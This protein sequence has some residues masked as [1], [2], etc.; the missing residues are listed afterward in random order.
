ME[1]ASLLHKH[2][3]QP[4]SMHRE[5]ARIAARFRGGVESAAL[6]CGLWPILDA[7]ALVSPFIPSHLTLHD[8][9][10]LDRL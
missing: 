10:H 1:P 6:A 7:C 3:S 5:I 2:A 8:Y 4:T 9:H